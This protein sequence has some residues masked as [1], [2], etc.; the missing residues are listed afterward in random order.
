MENKKGTQNRVG[1]IL[2]IAGL[3]INFVFC[4]ILILSEFRPDTPQN[5]ATE[6]TGRHYTI[7]L[8]GEMP[9][10]FML[11][12]IIISFSVITIIGIITAILQLCGKNIRITSLISALTSFLVFA[13]WLLFLIFYPDC[14]VVVLLLVAIIS[15]IG[16]ILSLAGLKNAL[17]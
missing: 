1:A 10:D 7:E 15:S 2:S 14:C 8:S 3:A 4:V 16:G 5:D 17:Q 6:G 13:G 12:I 11:K 9:S